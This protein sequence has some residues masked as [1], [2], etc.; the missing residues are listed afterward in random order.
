[1]RPEACKI[2]NVVKFQGNSVTRFVSL[3]KKLLTPRQWGRDGQNLIRWSGDRSSPVFFQLQTRSC[4]CGCD[5]A[6]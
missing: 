4:L 2:R 6:M 1:M 5:A 3:K